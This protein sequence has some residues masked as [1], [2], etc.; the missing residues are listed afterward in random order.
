[1]TA[2]QYNFPVYGTQGGGLARDV[3]GILVF[4]EK[5]DGCPE[6][7]VGDEVPCEW[8]IQPANRL[9]REEAFDQDDELNRGFDDFF[10]TAFE[11]VH[12][13][14]LSMGELEQFFPL[15]VRNQ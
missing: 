13:G 5:P 9:A 10:D 6:L 12:R 2:E 7:G 4:V 14:E 8:D 11:M 3:N 1:M 15:K